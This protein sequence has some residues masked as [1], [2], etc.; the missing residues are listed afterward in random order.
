[1]ALTHV[2]CACLLWLI[3]RPRYVSSICLIALASTAAGPLQIAMQPRIEYIWS[4]AFYYAIFSAVLYLVVATLMVVTAL[5]AQQ[6]HYSKDFQLTP[7]QRTLMLQTIMF[8]I[9]LLVGALVFS[10]V[11]GWAYLDAVYW[12][13]ATL[14]TVGFGDFAASTT[15]GRS[16]LFPYALIGIISLGLVIGSIRSLALERGRR[17]LDARIAEKRRRR[18][19]QRMTKKGRDDILEPISGQIEDASG[20]DAAN[21]VVLSEFKRREQEFELMR[22]IQEKAARRRR[23]TAMATSTFSCAVLWLVGAKIFQICEEPFQDWNYFDGVYFAVVSLTTIGYGD[24]TPVSN[25]GKAFFVFWS[26]LAL[27]TMTVLI[28]NAGDTIVKGIR[29]A[30][31][32]VGDMTILR[33]DRPLT[34]DLKT[35][36]KKLSFGRVF[37]EV[38]EEDAPGIFA[39]AQPTDDEA[40]ETEEEENAEAAGANDIDE[41]ANPPQSLEGEKLTIQTAGSSSVEPTSEPN[42]NSEA[43]L[44]QPRPSTSRASV[45]SDRSPADSPSPKMP[46]RLIKSL[47]TYSNRSN[48]T[49]LS[50]NSIR[51][52]TP[53]N[54]QRHD[55]STTSLSQADCLRELPKSRTEYR[56]M[57]I[58]E[59]AKLTQDLKRVPPRK[60]S[61]DDWAWY[62]K[63]IG[64]DEHNAETH[65]RAR[66]H[67]HDKTRARDAR[68]HPGEALSGETK[69]DEV[70]DEEHRVQWSWVGARSPLMGSQAEAEWLLEKLTKRLQAELRMAQKEDDERGGVDDEVNTR[71]SMET[72][73]EASPEPILEGHAT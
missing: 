57:L 53:T 30:T 69:S 67:V 64:E 28:S 52:A 62:L 36:L 51:S 66:P 72:G 34:K 11:E 70:G 16:L 71:A 33:E 27:P 14:F 17:R 23:W 48:R 42:P 29:D 12:A 6:G 46:R 58:D 73:K 61:F 63:L 45:K 56:C 37:S 24:V 60:Y 2:P 3:F 41:N 40:S 55:F 8:L 10:K 25:A 31:N 19:L 54:S 50:S 9:Y 68:R 15:L 44:E 13:D 18:M 4:Q 65:R 32:N 7:S 5:G 38:I 26:L 21:G 49:N 59:I 43:G 47:T 22:K 1:M 20:P 35:L 39:A